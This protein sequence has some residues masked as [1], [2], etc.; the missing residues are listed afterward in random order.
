[1]SLMNSKS[2]ALGSA[3][4]FANAAADLAGYVFADSIVD[5]TSEV[6][7]D[8]YPVIG[9]SDVNINKQFK[10]S[11]VTV[12]ALSALLATGLG[13]ACFDGLTTPKRETS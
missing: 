1:M 2:L 6:K 4:F 10:N 7:A 13:A 11:C 9:E 12:G 8:E 5:P 3:L